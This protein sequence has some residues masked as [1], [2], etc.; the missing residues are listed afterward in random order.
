MRLRPPLVGLAALAG[1]LIAGVAVLRLGQLER[2]TLTRWGRTLRGGAVTTAQ[3]IDDW[4]AERRSDAVALSQVVA[5]RSMDPATARNPNAARVLERQLEALQRH[6]KYPGVWLYDRTG[7]RVASVGGIEATHA[8]SLAAALAT[9][10][11]TVQ[12]AGP[13]R[14][15]DGSIALSIAAP[16]VPNGP[17]SPRPPVGEA[18]VMRSDLTKAFGSIGQ[19]R[20]NAA[21]SVTIVPS[22]DSLSALY[23][24]SSDTS[25]V[26]LGSARPFPAARLAVVGVDTFDVFTARTG[27][28]SARFL[29]ATSRLQTLPWGVLRRV[30]YRSAF[31]PFRTEVRLEAAFGLGLLALI[32]LSLFSVNRT[33][34]L[35]QL[36]EIAE[37]NERLRASETRFKTLV[38]SL[39]DVIITMDADRRYTGVFGRWL[40]K[41][42]LKASDML[43]KTTRELIGE[44]PAKVHDDAHARA[45]HG[46]HV[47]YEY[48]FP[49]SDDAPP[50]LFQAT[51]SPMYDAE[52]MVREVVAVARDVTDLKRASESLKQS[53]ASFRSFVENSPIGIYRATRGGRFLTVNASLANLLGY[54]N[55]AE[56]VRIDMARDLYRGPAERNALLRTLEAR[57]DVH[58]AEVEWRRKDGSYISVRISARAFRNEQGV[59]L[60]TEGFVE[61]VTP[62]RAAEQALRQS[63]K[64]AA[65]GQLVSGV[66]HELNNPLS[67]ILHFAEDLLHDTRPAAD[68]EALAVIRDQARRSRAIVRDLLS[69][70]RL[71]D[72]ARERVQLTHMLHLT[73]KA[74]RPQVEAIG[75]RLEV[76]IP[77]LPLAIESDRA[78]LE[79]VVTNLVVNAAQATAT[80]TSGGTVRLSCRADCKHFTIV[81]EDEGGGIPREIMDRIFEPFFTTK[82]L[83]EGTGLGLSV[84]LGIVQQLGGRITAENLGGEG[85]AGARFQVELPVDVAQLEPCPPEESS[86]RRTV[87]T[88]QAAQPAIGWAAHENRATSPA[89]ARRTTAPRGVPAIAGNGGSS[90]TPDTAAATPATQPRVL[91]IDDEPSIRMA[92]RRF[93]VRRGWDVRE[94]ADGES[95]LAMLLGAATVPAG[96]VEHRGNGDSAHTGNTESEFTVVISDLK[97]PGCS[98]VELHDR[99]AQSA[100]S[101][102]TRV[103]FSTGDV[104]SPE[105]AAFVQRTKCSVLQKPFELKM[106]DEV[107]TRLR[108]A[109]TVPADR[110]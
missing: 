6:G 99:L 81:V 16:V 73:A 103:V 40:D 11:G 5:V 56:L 86:T 68:A 24:C 93:F 97:M 91:I 76:A 77:D 98:G 65:L 42:R 4:F 26:C 37:T 14:L 10:T 67:A 12:V 107:V 96:R 20:P 109:A 79:Q 45:F 27:Q 110:T 17:T 38:E 44:G 88:P 90:R 85:R 25:G 61:D 82:P 87:T 34:R 23:Y 13:E 64:L 46:E 104:A 33:V 39:N 74:L 66:A 15:T 9:R 58:T 100:P 53:E 80:N 92:L 49:G 89:T 105:A 52:G 36:D 8:E 69:F 102:L 47:E 22:G 75:A 41:S 95:A 70:V 84:S 54:E 57:G 51:V 3:T 28:Y 50:T 30:D 63:E 35:R 94:A 78:G 83:G 62:L 18:V 19:S 7:R 1:V 48:D 21:M 2:E 32:G 72:S 101:L 29:T 60:F 55:E 59:V 31:E 43:G 108:N 106:L 71:R